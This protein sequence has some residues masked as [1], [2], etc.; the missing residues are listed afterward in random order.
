[1]EFDFKKSIKDAASRQAASSPSAGQDA[2]YDFGKAIKDAAQSQQKF[3]SPTQRY[4]LLQNPDVFADFLK[5]AESKYGFDMKQYDPLGKGRNPKSKKPTPGDEQFY[6]MFD[7]YAYNRERE[8]VHGKNKLNFGTPD[9]NPILHDDDD[10]EVWAD[11]YGTYN[12]LPSQQEFE[13][14]KVKFLTEK[15]EKSNKYVAGLLDAPY[16]AGEEYAPNGYWKQQGLAYD[17]ADVMD[18]KRKDAG[19]PPKS[20]LNLYNRSDPEDVLR[21]QHG[22][23]PRYYDNTAKALQEKKAFEDAVMQ[24]AAQ[25]KIKSADDINKLFYE[26][27]Y[28]YLRSIDDYLAAWNK[29]TET[30]GGYTEYDKLT[31]KDKKMPWQHL[32]LDAMQKAGYSITA[33]AGGFKS[34]DWLKK[35]AEKALADQGQKYGGSS[36]GKD[37]FQNV[38][39][40]FEE[41]PYEKQLRE[42][43]LV[44]A[45]K[46]PIT[47]MAAIQKGA[48]DKKNKYVNDEAWGVDFAQFGDASPLPPGMH[49]VKMISQEEA[50]RINYYYGIG[51]Y[52]TADKLFATYKDAH[53]V[54]YANTQSDKFAKEG[55][56]AQKVAL[57]LVASV[58]RIRYAGETLANTITGDGSAAP[59]SIATLQMRTAGAG[60]N[61]LTADMS[62]A[63]K[64]FADAGL[65][66]M[67]NA[68][69]MA[70]G[71]AAPYIMGTSAMG[72]ASLGAKDR[73]ATGGQQVSEGIAYGLAEYFGEKFAIKG[74]SKILSTPAKGF[75]PV[76]KQ[77]GA[78]MGTEFTEESATEVMQILSDVAIMGNKSEMASYF[79]DY[80]S[81]HPGKETDAVLSTVVKA[82][83]QIAYAGGQGAV[84]GAGM[85]GGTTLLGRAF[86]S[87]T[88]AP[89]QNAQ[90]PLQQQAQP[91]AVTPSAESDITAPQ[92]AAQSSVDTGMVATA[93]V[94][95]GAPST[96]TVNAPSA[97]S[98]APTNWQMAIDQQTA[99]AYYVT[100][101]KRFAIREQGDTYSLYE[102]VPSEGRTIA[103]ARGDFNSLKEAQTAAQSVGKGQAYTPGLQTQ[104]AA[105]G[106]GTDPRNLVNDLTQIVNDLTQI[107]NDATEL[108]TEGGRTVVSE[109]QKLIDEFV[110][111]SFDQ[112][113]ETASPSTT[114]MRDEMK[115]KGV[116][117]DSMKVLDRVI[118]AYENDMPQLIAKLRNEINT[119]RAAGGERVA[120]LR[121][122]KNAKLDALEAKRR[123]DLANLREYKNT[124][125]ER[126]KTKGA[127]SDLR[128]LYKNKE[129]KP[130]KPELHGAL[131]DFVE[132]IGDLRIRKDDKV[133]ASSLIRFIKDVASGKEVTAPDGT[134]RQLMDGAEPASDLVDM[135]NELNGKQIS[136]LSA[137]ELK[138]LRKA[139]KGIIQL[140]KDAYGVFYKGNAK[141]TA[142][143]IAEVKAAT[144]GMKDVSNARQGGPQNV[145]TRMLDRYLGAQSMELY[146]MVNTLMNSVKEDSFTYKVLSRALYDGDQARAAFHNDDFTMLTG[147]LKNVNHHTWFKTRASYKLASGESISLTKDELTSIYLNSIN[148][149]NRK[150]LLSK[151]KVDLSKEN[152]TLTDTDIDMLVEKATADADVK[153]VSDALADW[154]NTKVTER[155]NKTSNERDGY[156]RADVQNYWPIYRD[157]EE[158]TY[159]FQTVGADIES[160]GWLKRRVGGD[161]PIILRGAMDTA[162]KISNESG[163]YSAYA[164][165][166]KNMQRVIRT[167]EMRAI[168]RTKFGKSFESYFTSY[169]KD[170][171]LQQSPW[172]KGLDSA[173][174][175][176]AKGRQAATLGS[177]K[178]I[179]NQ[180][181]GVASAVGYLNAKYAPAGIRKADLSLMEKWAPQ[182]FARRRFGGSPEAGALMSSGLS[183]KT[184]VVEKVRAFSTV[185]IQKGDT[186]TMDYLWSWVLA[187]VK[188]TT[189]LTGDALYAETGRRLTEVVNRTQ[190]TGGIAT[191]SLVENTK[192]TV[193][194]IAMPFTS[195]VNKITNM[196]Y[197]AYL[198]LHTGNKARAAQRIVGVAANAIAF[199]LLTTLVKQLWKGEDDEPFISQLASET[200]E[201][202]ITTPYLVGQFYGSFIEGYKLSPLAE[203]S[204]Q[205]LIDAKDAIS[206]AVGGMAKVQS[207]KYDTPEKKAAAMKAANAKMAGS[208]KALGFAAAQFVGV[209]VYQHERD[210]L[211]PLLK[212]VSPESYYGYQGIFKADSGASK[213]FRA[214]AA[215]GNKEK[216]MAILQIDVNNRGQ[217][218]VKRSWQSLDWYKALTPAEQRTWDSVLRRTKPKGP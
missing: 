106:Y 154:V 127:L 205:D 53:A 13:G 3:S 142:D 35:L 97:E 169:L 26:G 213:D 83:E 152:R 150:S 160:Y 132:S 174:L 99:E 146:N 134:K 8:Q 56:T 14:S 194:K 112:A 77:I 173:L 86:N 184:S 23:I 114:A 162:V 170:G 217:D 10:N 71:P 210:L 54:E 212:M 151:M 48:A 16:K 124:A 176:L 156:D 192:S 138:L 50:D 123:A 82:V 70:T 107:V 207:A 30:E 144:D 11:F 141:R 145:V 28:K 85:G 139:I 9:Y 193:E 61:D 59:E 101:D 187:E 78:Q 117:R 168:M 143:V 24:L 51:D 190:P 159:S 163:T 79:N 185:G 108:N 181:A 22:E 47:D 214:A 36:S 45:L 29:A 204:L 161:A 100:G 20:Y 90:E 91:A 38:L 7:Q 55:T 116:S 49:G 21:L 157:G 120:K 68:P 196:T 96:Q 125:I 131:G 147:L 80:L 177:W 93:A 19:L 178:I 110:N 69:L 63:G 58:P 89:S 109:A 102:G 1:M 98:A 44:A 130:L 149:D 32:D 171:V 4:A 88:D 215:S 81:K 60:R 195:G 105:A 188:G 218:T 84:S 43:E 166:I 2:G 206:L 122:E 87:G 182:V 183:A 201:N 189:K 95:D 104:A 208:L 75:L 186:I 115:A 135:L 41:T 118:Q 148:E 64:F 34:S 136:E 133:N 62:P 6:S 46:A 128:S 52:K 94:P 172:H 33:D 119:V 216:A 126:T 111:I 103:T 180:F 67:E 74:L 191:R 137:N 203:Q 199:G 5:T 66:L 197:D 211:L 92:E 65:S 39:G 57:S 73:G 175:W 27:N 113:D 179:L 155:V 25:N 76:V 72:Q 42:P 121:A 17:E 12:R 40:W 15:K 209:S 200:L 158:R 165:P 202:L 18:L 37:W 31:G 129:Q 140:N 153:R 167:P 164:V 198:S